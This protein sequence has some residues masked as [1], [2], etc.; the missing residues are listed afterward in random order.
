MATEQILSTLTINKVDSEETFK[1][2]KAAGL[3]NDDELY[4]TP[5]GV[6][7]TEDQITVSETEPADAV[8]NDLWLDL[9]EDA[10]ASLPISGGTLTGPLVMSNNKITE[11]GDPTSAQD[12]ATKNYVDKSNLTFTGT[13]DGDFINITATSW[14]PTSF[15]EIG[16]VINNGG[17][18][19]LVLTGDSIPVAGA[20]TLYATSYDD[21]TNIVLF[22]TTQI[23]SC[24]MVVE[25]QNDY[26]FGVVTFGE[27]Y[28]YDN[29]TGETNA[30][31]E[32]PAEKLT[33]SGTTNITL[34]DNYDY[35][36]NNVSTLNLTAGTGSCHG[37]ITFGSST[38]TVSLH[39]FT[40]VD[41]DIAN[42]A[43]ST[44]WEFSCYNKYII[45]KN[46]SDV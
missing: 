24:L 37:F 7:G 1:K 18:V 39:G 14:T 41:G 12:V 17:T 32:L 4:L 9:D 26:S 25:M 35:T 19:K 34:Q 44:V 2:M 30:N 43:A 13:Y 15:S 28:Y 10:P 8:E 3:V 6:A 33:A 45:F 20:L 38:P 11:V 31:F 29:I 21:I 36:F 22:S 42:A 16:E 23:S 27:V 46:W 40:K 5:N